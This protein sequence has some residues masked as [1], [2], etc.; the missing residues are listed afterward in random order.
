MSKEIAE[1]WAEI[2]GGTI[3]REFYGEEEWWVDLHG[4]K[5]SVPQECF[6][7]GVLAVLDGIP[8]PN[9]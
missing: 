8:H 4:R 6:R 5:L 1:M 2:L 9:A 7:I 3:D